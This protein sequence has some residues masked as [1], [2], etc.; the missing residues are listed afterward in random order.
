ML[1]TDKPFQDLCAAIEV[2]NVI[3]IIGFDL[4]NSAFENENAG[5][6]TFLAEQYNGALCRELR[7]K[8]NFVNGYDLINGIYHTLNKNAKIAFAKNISDIIVR[9]RTDID[10]VPPCFEQLARIKGFRF[11]INATFLNSL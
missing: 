3:P 10:L 5:I 7:K 11:Y 8:H 6:L 1:P 2:N 9:L 4:F